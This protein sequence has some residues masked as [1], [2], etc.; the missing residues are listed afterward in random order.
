MYLLSICPAPGTTLEL[1]RQPSLALGSHA[2]EALRTRGQA[3]KLSSHQLSE[4]LGMLYAEALLAQVSA[5]KAFSGVSKPPGPGH[6]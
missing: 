4:V 5:G 3:S 1:E 2:R 6:C